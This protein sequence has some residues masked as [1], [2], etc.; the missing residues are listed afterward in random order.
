MPD[1]NLNS[2]YEIIVSGSEQLR[3]SNSDI[4]IAIGGGRIIDVAKLICT[5]AFSIHNYESII[6]GNE[7]IANNV[8]PAPTLS[9]TFFAKAGQ[10]KNSL[11][12]KAIVPLLP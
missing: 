4:V 8:S 3:Q 11:L 2:Y 1:S 10:C 6:R 5:A 7:V 9:T 12:S